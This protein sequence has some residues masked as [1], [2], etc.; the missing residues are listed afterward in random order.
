VFLKLDSLAERQKRPFLTLYD[1][2]RYS[3]DVSRRPLLFYSLD[4]ERCFLLKTKTA[5]SVT[6]MNDG[7][8]RNEGN[9]GITGS[10]P[11]A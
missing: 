6:V 4:G 11:K 9:S 5:K 2:S 8:T 1:I 3:G 10:G 7:R